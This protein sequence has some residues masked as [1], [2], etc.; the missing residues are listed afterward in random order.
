MSDNTAG[1]QGEP[2]DRPLGGTD[3][4]GQPPPLVKSSTLQQPSSISSPLLQTATRNDL[5]SSNLQGNAVGLNVLTGMQQQ[6]VLLANAARLETIN[7]NTHESETTEVTSN[8]VGGEGGNGGG[9]GAGREGG[10]G[11]EDG[12]GGEGGNEETT[13]PAPEGIVPN[14]DDINLNLSP[15]TNVGN[16]TQ[17]FD[18]PNGDL[19]GK[20][21]SYGEG[22]LKSYE[23]EDEG[24][25]NSAYVALATADQEHPTSFTSGTGQNVNVN[26]GGNV[27]SN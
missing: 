13:S 20:D 9:D 26:Q 2:V 22:Y 3:S 12:A 8:V 5:L 10:D 1:L 19:N 6:E 25:N 15:I 27:Q 21:E 4:Q 23:E 16:Q 17:I 24:L 11:G 18:N 14:Q 7:K